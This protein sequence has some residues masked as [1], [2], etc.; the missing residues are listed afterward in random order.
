MEVE[1]VHVL[2]GRAVRGNDSDT[3]D[4]GSVRPTLS[5]TAYNSA[6][7]AQHTSVHTGTLRMICVENGDPQEVVVREE[8]CRRRLSIERVSLRFTASLMIIKIPTLML[9][10]S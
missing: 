5:G 8:A 3:L 1:Y 9:P 7:P 2:V 10:S 6:F 4:I